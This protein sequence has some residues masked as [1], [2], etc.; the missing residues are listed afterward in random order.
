MEDSDGISSA[1]GVESP[2]IE[3]GSG[4]TGDTVRLGQGRTRR[5]RMRSSSNLYRLNSPPI[6][7]IIDWQI[8]RCRPGGWSRRE[9][10]SKSTARLTSKSVTSRGSICPLSVID[11]S[12]HRLSIWRHQMSIRPPASDLRQA[13]KSN[14]YSTNSILI[15]SL[16]TVRL[17]S[18]SL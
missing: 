4:R 14:S 16:P 8:M 12:S 2:G 10:A 5:L 17:A 1:A 15:T 13:T 7:F 3:S 6:C 18:L 9:G 11:T